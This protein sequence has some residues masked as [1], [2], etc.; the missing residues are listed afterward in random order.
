MPVLIHFL[1]SWH[2]TG[3]HPF[4]IGMYLHI[5]THIYV[6]KFTS[7]K[8]CLHIFHIVAL[9]FSFREGLFSS[10]A[11]FVLEGGSRSLLLLRCFL[12]TKSSA[13]WVEKA[14]VNG[15]NVAYLGG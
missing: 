12:G 6:H 14:Q 10:G 4:Y 5:Y 13:F 8:E 11:M 7:Q 15:K 9:E 3:A 1:T 2:N